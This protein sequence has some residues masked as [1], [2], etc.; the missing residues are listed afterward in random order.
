LNK[1]NKND[2]KNMNEIYMHKTLFFKN[3]YIHKKEK[4]MNWEKKIRIC[5]GFFSNH[6]YDDSIPYMMNCDTILYAMIIW[7]FLLH[8][9][10]KNDEQYFGKT[11]I[12][13][14]FKPWKIIWKGFAYIWKERWTMFLQSCQLKKVLENHEKT[15]GFEWDC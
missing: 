15:W 6:I 12:K 14:R 7:L 9:Y 8:I 3:S 13:N 10:E 11:V 4:T 5:I 2:R 1:E